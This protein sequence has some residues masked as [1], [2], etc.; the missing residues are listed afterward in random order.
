MLVLTS[1]PQLFLTV[2]WLVEPPRLTLWC[3]LAPLPSKLSK[4]KACCLFI[5]APDSWISGCSPLWHDDTLQRFEQHHAAACCH[6]N[7]PRGRIG[8]APNKDDYNRSHGDEASLN[9]GFLWLCLC[10]Q[11][12]RRDIMFAVSANHRYRYRSHREEE[13][14]MVVDL[15]QAKTAATVWARQRIFLRTFK[16]IFLLTEKSIHD[17]SD[18]NEYFSS[19]HDV[20]LTLEKHS[21]L[22]REK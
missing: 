15:L 7:A 6:R 14:E 2:R 5:S 13:E 21:V 11:L 17:H 20:F 18:Q 12:C 9:S 3:F 10:L 16:A 19:T 4:T 1:K 22:T 8:E